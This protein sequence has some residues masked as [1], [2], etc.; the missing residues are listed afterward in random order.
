MKTHAEVHEAVAR[1]LTV[2]EVCKGVK[3]KDFMIT[4]S[5]MQHADRVVTVNWNCS[6]SFVGAEWAHIFEVARDP[7][8]LL[9]QVREAIKDRK[10]SAALDILRGPAPVDTLIPTTAA[11]ATPTPEADPAT[12]SHYHPTGEFPR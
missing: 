11:P 9:E 1:L 2:E 10:N 3:C 12:P 5:S 6:I 7:G 4:T 8:E